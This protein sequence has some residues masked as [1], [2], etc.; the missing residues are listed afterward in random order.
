VTAIDG[1]SIGHA[2]DPAAKTGVT[3]FLPHAPAVAAVHVA[4][5]APASRETDLLRPGNLVERIDAIVFSGGSAFGL[6]AADGVMHWLAAQGRGFAVGATRVPIV[7][8]ASLFDLANGG[9]KARLSAGGLSIYPALGA[10]ACEAAVASPAVG[11]VGAGIG[12]TTADLKGG[13][14]AATAELSGGGRVAAYA[15]VN[16]VGRV[17]LG[18]TPHFRAA[19]FEVDGELGGLGFPSPLP[20]DAAAVVTK[21]P[22]EPQASTTLALVATDC[23]LNRD[24][25]QRLAVAAHDGIAL[26]VYPAHT[27]FDGDTV[28]AL[29]SGVRALESGPRGL[30]EL[31]AAATA[32]LTRAIARAVFAATP[33]PGDRHPTWSGRYGG[34]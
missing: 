11:S 2:Q 21:R 5:G 7:P 3:V 14:G 33:A 19:P 23:I 34:S 4:G 30:L 26:A 6:A 9:D 1:L 29:S 15:A 10:A 18:S 25:A 13:F 8:A 22:L 16:C 27:P 24:E 32:A 17:T 12:A 31:C 28:F 20:P